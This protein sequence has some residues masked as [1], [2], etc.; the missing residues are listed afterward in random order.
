MI[1][2]YKGYRITTTEGAQQTFLSVGEVVGS[3]TAPIQ[4]KKFQGSSGARRSIA[5]VKRLI[6]QR[7]AA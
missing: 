4:S 3:K 6:D 7:Q 1:T 5:H 2:L